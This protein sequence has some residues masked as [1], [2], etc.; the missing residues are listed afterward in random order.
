[1]RHE[2]FVKGSIKND[3]VA[4]REF[5][6]F[7]YP[8]LMAV[9]LRMSPDDDIANDLM[10]DAFIRIFKNLHIVKGHNVELI[11]SWCRK[12]L[13]N[14]ILDYIRKESKQSFVEYGKHEECEQS[15]IYSD[16]DEEE[17][18]YLIEKGVDVKDLT[19]AIKS[20]PRQY[21]L[22]FNMFIM[23]GLSHKEIGEVLSISTSTSKSY[24]FKA[25]KKLREKL[26]AI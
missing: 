14:R 9:S 26:E 2:D 4:Q 1:M 21:G 8:K 19:T 17:V 7:Y 22:V 15:I 20:L 5:Y 12:I 3:I 16:S 24:L 25:K 18:G 13:T 10:Q 6:K 23:E 11:Y